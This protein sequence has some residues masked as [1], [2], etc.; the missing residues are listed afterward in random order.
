MSDRTN[1]ERQR[2]YIAR[3]KAQAGLMAES[4]RLM[5]GLASDHV[6]LVK[7]LAQA[8]AQIAEQVAEIARL[9]LRKPAAAEE[10]SQARHETSEPR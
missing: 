9:R 7:K 4:E 1:A 8:R 3:L 5:P 10:H 6:A 2:R